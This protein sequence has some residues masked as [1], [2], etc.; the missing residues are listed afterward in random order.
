MSFELKSYTV[1]YCTA[2]D[3]CLNTGTV[4]CRTVQCCRVLPVEFFTQLHLIRFAI[5]RLFNSALHEQMG[6]ATNSLLT[7][8][9]STHQFFW[10]RR[11]QRSTKTRLRWKLWLTVLPVSM[12]FFGMF[13]LIRPLSGNRK[14]TLKLLKFL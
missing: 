8:F 14:L 13:I 1:Q 10:S 7:F 6:I 4:V 3:V 2:R 12:K 9:C 11:L 5:V